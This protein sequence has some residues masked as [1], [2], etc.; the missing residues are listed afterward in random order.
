VSTRRNN[1]IFLHVLAW[2]GYPL[3]LTAIPATVQRARLLNGGKVEVQQDSDKLI[4]RVPTSSRQEID[5][6]IL[7]DL[8]RSA[9]DLAPVNVNPAGKLTPAKPGN[10]KSTGESRTSWTTDPGVKLA[11]VEGAALGAGS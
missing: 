2:D 4:V 1:S 11:E 8:D 10:A 5:T 3:T 6:V 9:M 7:L